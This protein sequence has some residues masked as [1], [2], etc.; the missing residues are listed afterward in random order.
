MFDTAD[1][2]FASLRRR[3]REQLHTI[4]KSSNPQRP[5]WIILRGPR[6]RHENRS[7]H[8][9]HHIIIPRAIIYHFPEPPPHLVYLTRFA[10][11]VV[12]LAISTERRRTLVG[13]VH[14]PAL[15]ADAEFALESFLDSLC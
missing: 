6:L 9:I 8:V 3:I 13:S 14:V 11:L 15:S 2:Q 4:K 7:K 10:R 5:S 1:G 12:P